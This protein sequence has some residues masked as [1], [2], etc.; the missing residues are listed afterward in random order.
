MYITNIILENFRNYKKINIDFSEYCNIITGRNAQG[1][2]NLL[3]A[4]FLCA[5]GKTNRGS[6]DMDIIKK[7]Y[8]N[9]SVNI[10]YYKD[11]NK[12]TITIFYDKSLGKMIKINEIPI[13]KFSELMGHFNV[14]MFSPNDL[15]LVKEGPKERRKFLDMA[16]SQLKPMYFYEIQQ[17][18]MILNERNSLL[19]LIREK[20]ANR[21]D[22]NIWNE[23]LIN[24]AK[25][26]IKLRLEFL[27][28]I[29]TI[30]SSIH[31]SI[32][33]NTE[34][35]DIKYNF[36]GLD[37][38]KDSNLDLENILRKLLSR[39]ENNDI[40]R[41]T[42]SI[43]PHRDDFN[44]DINEM[45]SKLYASQGQ[46]RTIVLTLTLAKLMVSKGETGEYPVLLLDDVMSE[47]DSY[48]QKYLLN[49]LSGIQS[50]VT[51]TE[52]NEQYCNIYAQTC[53]YNIDD[54]VISKLN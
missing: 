25:K 54:G 43:G 48:R 32:T 14:V 51:N 16:I 6:K 40:M 45:D 20:K 15:S 42:T 29:K 17:Y 7:G 26:I 8:D 24:S 22:L 39:A 28:K 37:N 46:Q 31:S 4:M 34:K 47:L 35:L 9:F 13:K 3:E 53:L 2:T 44:I 12:N 23:S 21:N 1:K 41:G 33:E 36:N 27:E 52:Y 49:Q 38:L 50:F 10:T 5:Y 30:S 19:K 18:G 11:S